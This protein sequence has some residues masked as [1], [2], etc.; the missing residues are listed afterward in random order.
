MNKEQLDI[1]NTIDMQG[2]TCELS[3]NILEEILKE[4]FTIKSSNIM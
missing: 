2:G 4:D 1:F 3:S